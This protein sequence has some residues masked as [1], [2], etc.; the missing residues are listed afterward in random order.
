MV[1]IPDGWPAFHSPAQSGRAGR[2]KLTP[3]PRQS[4]FDYSARVTGVPLQPSQ[5]QGII[6]GS[7]SLT[8]TLGPTGVGNVWYPAQATISTTTGVFDSST[9]K[10]FLGPAGIPIQ[11]VGTLFPGGSGTIA[12][13]IPSMSP[14]QYLI[15]VWTGA[16]PGDLASLNII[17]AMD[18][19]A[20]P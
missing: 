4:I 14:G 17:G 2:P 20:Q 19:L 7:G 13:A 12:L 18:A 15:G 1:R 11:M 16:H 5:A 8:V 6:P 10:L 9:F 3:I